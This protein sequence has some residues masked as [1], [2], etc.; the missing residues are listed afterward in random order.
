[1]PITVKKSADVSG[2]VKKMLAKAESATNQKNYGYA[3]QILRDMLL[4]EPGLNDARIMLRQAQLE[5]IAFTAKLGRQLGA[6]MTTAWPV[7]VKGP[8][9]LKKG[10]FAKAFDVAEKAM[11]VDP[12]VLSSLK[13]LAKVAEAAELPEIAVNALEVAVRFHPKNRGVMMELAELYK[14]VEEPRKAVQ[15]LQKSLALSPGDLEAQNE[16]KHATALAAMQDAKWEEAGSYRDVIK[17]KE[18]AQTLEQ[19]TRVAARDD[20]TR[21]SLIDVTLKEIEGKPTAS[22]YR[23]LGELYRQAGDFDQAI[24][25][26]GQIPE[27]TGTRD[28]AID[29]TITD[30]M[31][32]KFDK[33]L[34]DLRDQLAAQPDAAA[35]IQPAI[36]QIEAERRTILLERFEQRVESYPNEPR[37]RF[38]LGLMYWENERM[39]DAMTQLQ[40]A[41]RHISVQARSQLY[42][43]RCLAA[44]G[45]AEMAIEQFNAALEQRERLAPKDIKDALYEVA[46][47]HEGKGDVEQALGRIRELYAI[48]VNYRD[49]SQRIERYYAAQK[50]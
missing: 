32:E 5:R 24:A 43:G 34:N 20:D 50:K 47:V 6:M 48:D 21:Q 16:L 37:F 1:M 45:L 17:D 7:Y 36:D 12:T 30:I 41:Q 14:K 35:E 39:D 23:Q 15:I 42:M 8:M 27:L 33:Q 11:E 22:K 31:R 3:S 28:P 40:Q 9:L 13:F 10:E 49:I 2:P 18:Q 38:E 4:I 19:K 25:A 46:L 44:K 29:S 26:F